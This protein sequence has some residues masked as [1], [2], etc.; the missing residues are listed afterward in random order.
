MVRTFSPRAWRDRM[1][2]SRPAPGPF[3][4]T[5]IS[6]TPIFR[7]PSAAFSAARWAAKGVD[8]REPLNPIVPADAQQRTSPFGSAIETIV[9]LKEAL[10]CA[11]AFGT[12]RLAFFF[13]PMAIFYLIS[14]TLRLPATVFRGPFR[15]RA[16]VRVRWPRTGRPRRWRIPR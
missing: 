6:F 11:I 16:L 10:T 8:L 4:R 15:V 9:L 13:F 2:D 7:A 12:V 3:T 1:A 14:F 5:S